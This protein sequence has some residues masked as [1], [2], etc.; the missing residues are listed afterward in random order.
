[1]PRE[2]SALGIDHGSRQ[3]HTAACVSHKVS[4]SSP[5]ARRPTFIGDP[6]GQS[7]TYI[8]GTLLDS[9]ASLTSNISA[10]ASTTF[11][12]LAR[13]HRAMAAA[14]ATLAPVSTPMP[15]RAIPDSI[16]SS[17][18][19]WWAVSAKA[20]ALSEERL[21]RRLPYFLPT[22]TPTPSPS[23]PVTARVDQITLDTPKKYINTVSFLPGTPAPAHRAPPPTVVLH[24]YGAGLGFYWPNFETFGQWT[25][26]RGAP[27]YL[28]DWLGMGRSA[29]VPF[30]VKAKRDDVD[31]RVNEAESFFIDS[32]EL[33][34]QKMGLNKINLVGHSLGAVSLFLSAMTL[35]PLLTR[36]CSTYL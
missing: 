20:S 34:R 33:W 14:T 3:R 31:G 29:R 28:L 35:R 9:A 15:A 23:P 7:A 18:K 30:A 6:L 21:L 27:V 13:L 2:H 32:L 5:P 4:A 17:L 26:R 1:M 8:T 19:S 22:G 36:P 12:R 16:G 24:G 11:R 10:S 25:A